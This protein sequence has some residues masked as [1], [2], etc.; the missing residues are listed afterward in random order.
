MKLSHVLCMIVCV[1]SGPARGA[2]G[3][4]TDTSVSPHVRLRSVKIDA[5]QWTDGFWAERSEWCRRTVI[6]NM[7]GLFEDPNISRAYEN[8]LVAAGRKEGRHR[9]PKWNDGDFLKWLEAVA[10]VYATTRDE[11]LDR[12]MDDIIEVIGKAQRED[13]YFHTPMVIAQRQGL[14]GVDEFGDRLA[15][16]TYNMGHLMTCA[17][18]H[19]RATGKTSLLDIAKKAT[20]FLYRTYK[21]SPDTLAN[22]GI[23][24]SHYMG[25]V[26]MYRTT[27]DPRYL[28]LARGLID[29]R[30]RVQ[31]GTDD[32]QDRIAFRRQTEAVGHAVRANYLY[33][34]AADVYAETGDASLLGALEKIWQDVALRKLYVT[35]GTGALYNGASPD[36]SRA[37]SSITPVHQAY[38]RPYQLPNVTAHNESCAT[39][40]LILWNWRMLAI[41]GQARFADQLELALYNGLLASISLDGKAFFYTNPL[42]KVNELPFDLRWSRQRERYISCFCCPPNVVRTIAETSAYAYSV[43]DEGVWVNLYGSNALDSRLPDGAPVKLRQQTDYPWEDTIRI[44]VEAMPSSVS[45]LFLRIPG[46]T[47]DARVTINDRPAGTNLQA[48]QYFEIRRLW[49]VGDRVELVLPMPVQLLEAHRLVEE[50]RNQAA[51][52]RGPIVYCLESVDLPHGTE[53]ADVTI[54]P[55]VRMETRYE[56]SLLG[57][58]TVLEA[59]AIAREGR[60]WDSALYQ[61]IASGPAKTIDIRMI[62][63]YAWGNRGDAEMSVWVPLASAAPSDPMFVLDAQAFRH[64]VEFFNDMEPENIANYVP[65]RQSWAWM[66]DNVPFFECPDK[67]F[68][69]V[70]YY[71]WWTFRK[72]LKQTSDG[73]V[74]TEFL[75]KVSH[76]G[77]HNTISCALG[78]HIAEGMW[79]RDQRYI[80]EYARFWYVGHE[81]HLQPHFHK[82]SNWATAALHRRYLVNRDRAFLTNLLDAFVADHE[83][84]AQEQGVDSGLFWQYDVRDGME[85]SISGGR[86][87]RN[88][89]PPLNSYLYANATAISKVAEMAGRDGLA[90]EYAEKAARLRSLIHELLWDADADFFKVRRPDGTLADVREAI[91]FI[92]WC[93]HLPEPG[94]ERAWRQLLDS[95]GFKAPMGITT[96]ERRHPQFRSHGVGTCEWDGPVWPFATSQT[97]EALANVLRDYPQSYVSRADY[98]EAL[99]TYARSHQYRGKPYIGE[100]L[101]ENDGTWL[102]PDSAR[103]RY[104]NHSTFCD[105]VIRGLVGLVPRDDD[106]I[107]VD[108]LIPADAWDWFC[109]DNVPYHGRTLTVLWD[110]TGEKYH[111]GRGLLVFADGVEIARSDELTRVT[112]KLLPSLRFGRLEDF[113]R[114]GVAELDLVRGIVAQDDGPGVLAPKEQGGALDLVQ[115]GHAIEEELIDIRS[116]HGPLPRLDSDLVQG[117]VL[118]AGDACP[119]LGVLDGDIG[120]RDVLQ[121]LLR[122]ADQSDGLR[123][124]VD[125]DIADIDVAEQGGRTARIRAGVERVDV[126]GLAIDVLHADVANEDVLDHVAATSFGLEADPPVAALEIGVV[127]VDVFDSARG[128]TAEYDAAAAGAHLAGLEIPHHDVPGGSVDPQAFF[129]EAGLQDHGVIAG[130]EVVVLDQDVLRRIH[131]HAVAVGTAQAVDRH[132]AH[133]GPPAVD[134]VNVP[135]GRVVQGDALDQNVLRLPEDHEVGSHPL[136]ARALAEMAARQRHLGGNGPGRGLAPLPPGFALAL[137]DTLAGN[138]HVLHFKGVDQGGIVEGLHAFVAVL[139]HGQVIVPVRT[140]ADRGAFGEMQVDMTGQVNRAGEPSS[141]R[142]QHR[143]ATVLGCRGDGPVNGVRDPD[144]GVLA[145]LAGPVIADVEGPG[146]EGRTLQLGHGKGGLDWSDI[147]GDLRGLAAARCSQDQHTSGCRRQRRCSVALTHQHALSSL[148]LFRI[149]DAAQGTLPKPYGLCVL[150]LAETLKN[151]NAC[152]LAKGIS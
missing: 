112:G 93:F 85:E 47:K 18:V 48:G 104:Y 37:Q 100:Y 3:G 152:R 53:L 81:G 105:L 129:V 101:D 102:K 15:F 38:G 21:D 59:K 117:Q 45:S 10:F 108:P 26:E 34:G 143:A 51:V 142:D 13:G 23:C 36:G 116:D 130:L 5:V 127:H 80:D 94:Y 56:A 136:H 35:G 109:L 88:L 43:S 74:F 77:K 83:A 131:H 65:N 132:V 150:N 144:V 33:A 139:D 40:G 7:W 62:P 52:R 22:N 79:L 126:D 92:P 133:D 50:T 31:G 60:D 96:A 119:D 30:D 71:R 128:L 46:W 19:Y 87:V 120:Q 91:G 98:F 135:H 114:E 61:E 134:Q 107:V 14:P 73:F 29:I 106:T 147:P 16:E 78:H 44:I 113:G 17:C 149:L 32:N 58:V 68:E 76:S 8:F 97:L 145:H 75:D 103:S 138:G 42:A 146:R 70:Y 67:G 49:S 4:L 39:V 121:P 1:G 95:Q 99:L 125:L 124:A 55:D 54:P 82:Y 64:H 25:V 89:R 110:R 11:E 84:W 122:Q 24:P 72:H 12:H 28:E 90:R 118:D 137:E 66:R 6:P 148:F 115:K 9:G 141:R 123:H 20:D 86:R 140:E 41:T 57:G 151:V 2:V 63:Y 27:G 111:R 69:Q